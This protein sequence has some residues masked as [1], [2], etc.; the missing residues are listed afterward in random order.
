MHSHTA[1]MGGCGKIPAAQTVNRYKYEAGYS[2]IVITEHY[3]KQF[4]LE[5]SSL[6]FRSQIERYLKGYIA[7]LEA[8]NKIGFTVI[9][10]LE[11]RFTENANDYLV[12]GMDEDFL[13]EHENLCDLSI[14]EFKKKADENNLLIYQAHPFRPYMIPMPKY[15]H[16][17]EV[18]NG[19]ARHNSQN[20]KA[21]QFAMDNNLKMISGSDYHEPEDFARGGIIL[22]EKVNSSKELV[23]ILKTSQVGL[24]TT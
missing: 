24:I 13:Y 10:G 23:N 6:P 11:I 20:D 17:V 1:E 14:K 22:S 21:L 8:G 19:N 15:I 2:G 16:G 18:Y 9:L 5:H 4:F 12:Y 7:A 3:H